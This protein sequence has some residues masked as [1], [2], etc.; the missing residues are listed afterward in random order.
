MKKELSVII[1]T[2][3]RRESLRECLESLFVQNYP[4][5][6]YEIIVVDD[7]SPIGT[8]ELVGNL[9][10]RGNNNLVYLRQE[11]RGTAA[12]SNLG[13]RYAKSNIVAFTEDDCIMPC[14]WIGKIV[15]FHKRYPNV[16][17]IQGTILNYYR[18]NLIAT[19]EQKINDTYLDY[20]LYE[21][22]DNKYITLFYTGNC[23]LKIEI[24]K[25]QDIVFNKQLLACEDVDLSNQLLEKGLKILYTE[26][27]SVLHKY[28]TNIASFTKKHFRD[29]R[30]R[31]LLR[32]IWHKTERDYNTKRFSPIKFF[33]KM[34]FEYLRNYKLKGIILIALHILRK[35]ARSLGYL[36]Q[37]MTLGDDFVYKRI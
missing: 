4:K 17:A 16:A 24:F 8:K 33:L 19:L 30:W 12:A 22:D 37:K 25:E 14:D 10:K 3:N 35:L 34:D 11:H 1:P 28:R 18:N 9:I 20:I 31:Y 6:A 7:G 26:R 13:M 32:L 36:Y 2:C 29:G 23:S 5:D 27:I 21:E 15:Y